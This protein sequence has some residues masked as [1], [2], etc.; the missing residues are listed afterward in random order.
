MTDN[1]EPEGL[2]EQRDRSEKQ[3]ESWKGGRGTER[4]DGIKDDKAGRREGN[5]NEKEEQR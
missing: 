1:R 4:G 3:T 5:Q 2:W